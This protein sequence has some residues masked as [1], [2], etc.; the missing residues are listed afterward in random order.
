MAA[1]GAEGGGQR[2]LKYRQRPHACQHAQRTHLRVVLPEHRQEGLA[3]QVIIFLQQRLVDL[4]A[5]RQGGRQGG[6]RTLPLTAK[7]WGRR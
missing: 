7:P 3:Q 1:S 5:T 6:G 4:Q 2:T